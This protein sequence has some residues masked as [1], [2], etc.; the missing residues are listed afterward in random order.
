MKNKS[1]LIFALS[2]A[3]AGVFLL[4]LAKIVPLLLIFGVGPAIVGSCVMAAVAQDVPVGKVRA[5]AALLLSVPAYLLAFAS[6]AATASF[7]QRHGRT[8]ST[9][10]SDLGPDI[11][12]GLVAAVVIAG[13]LLELVAFLLSGRWSTLAALALVSGGLGSIVCAYAAK[14]SYFHLA[15]APE[16]QAQIAILFGPLFILG[17]AITTMVIGEQIKNSDRA[18]ARLHY[19]AQ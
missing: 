17:G 1:P 13:V 3:V 16:G 12:L 8:P 4:V 18:T 11:V 19:D 15:G 5:V 2:G 6:F 10:I 7:F 14:V 9:L